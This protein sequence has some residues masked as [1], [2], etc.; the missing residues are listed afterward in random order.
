MFGLPSG[1]VP[2]S[3]AAFKDAFLA[4]RQSVRLHFVTFDA[5]LEDAAKKLMPEAVA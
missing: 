3:L 4:L 1:Q 5:K 2:L